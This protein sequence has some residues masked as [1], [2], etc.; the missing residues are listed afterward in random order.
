MKDLNLDLLGTRNP[1]GGDMS[2]VIREEPCQSKV[3]D[4]G[5]EM[6]I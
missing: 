4:L 1:G 3:R 5:I 6:V 2:M